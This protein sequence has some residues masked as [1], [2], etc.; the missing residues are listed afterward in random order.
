M[1]VTPLQLWWP[2]SSIKMVSHCDCKHIFV[3]KVTSLNTSNIVNLRTLLL[4]SN[5]CLQG[6]IVYTYESAIAC[7]QVF[8]CICVCAYYNAH[9]THTHAHA[10]THAHTQHTHTDTQTH[11]LTHKISMIQHRAPGTYPDDQCFDLG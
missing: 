6:C 3:G 1:V 9:N 10:H 11:H 8:V 7:T 2:T 4:T 5:G